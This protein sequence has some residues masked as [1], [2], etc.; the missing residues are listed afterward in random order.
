MMDVVSMRRIVAEPPVSVTFGT[1]G[2]RGSFV[3]WDGVEDGRNFY[4]NLRNGKGAAV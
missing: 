4:G 3:L 1:M 2:R